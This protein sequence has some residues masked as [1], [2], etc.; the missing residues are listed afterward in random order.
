MTQVS[1]AI[2]A[3]ISSDDGSALG[4]ARQI[5]DCQKLAREKGW[6][7]AETFTD[8]DV[9]A[10]TTKVRPEYQRML[11]ALRSGQVNG[12]VVWDIDRLTRTPRELE[13]VITLADSHGV[14][15][16]SVGGEVDLSTPQG[17]LTARLKGSVARHEVEQSSRRL[18]RKFLE[19]AEAG[20]PHGKVAYG[21]AREPLYDD[22]G[23]VVGT[24]DVIHAEQAGV[25]REATRRVLDR[26]S[27][28]SIVTDLNARGIATPRGNKWDGA[29]LRQ[30]LLRERNAGRRVHRG[31]VIGR[32]DWEPLLD[33]G[34]FDRMVALLTDPAR[35]TARGNENVH[36]LSGIARCGLCDGLM[37]VVSRKT[38]GTKTQPAAYNCRSCFRI[39]RKQADVDELVETVILRRLAMPDGPD[40]LGGDPQIL[41][42]AV[43]EAEALDARLNLAAD[44]YADGMLTAEQLGRITAKIRPRLEK[45]KAR[46]R[47]AAPTPELRRFAGADAAKAWDAADVTIKRALIGLLVSVT[48]LPTG[49]GGGFAPES[50]RIEW[51]AR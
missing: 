50:V 42:E 23:H 44:Q 34:T 13:D 47:A 16:A 39:R 45:A 36:L 46:A 28:R 22:A 21:Y 38:N 18:K 26:E 30:V 29:M 17:R 3:R 12:L 4:V 25:I 40:L 37:R 35:R 10:S 51:K 7:V 15:L 5:E 24:R 2:Y 14:A 20:K 19:R 11:E 9:S 32:G 6:I 43:D 41:R 8:N 33:E 1:A 31:E 48:V 49:S 27:V